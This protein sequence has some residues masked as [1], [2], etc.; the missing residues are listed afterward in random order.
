MDVCILC[1][2][3]FNLE[4]S[5]IYQFYIHALYITSVFLHEMIPKNRKIV[6]Q[7]DE[8]LLKLIK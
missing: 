1:P 7:T 8:S 4:Y 5:L 6:F 3:D 2:I